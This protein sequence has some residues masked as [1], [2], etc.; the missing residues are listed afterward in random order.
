MSPRIRFRYV[1]VDLIDIRSSDIY[2][3][4]ICAWKWQYEQSRGNLQRHTKLDLDPRKRLNAF[5]HG[6][7]NNS[8]SPGT[9]RALVQR[10][11]RFT[12]PSPA[13]DVAVRLP[14]DPKRA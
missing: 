4:E 12:V 3:W 10:R 5:C 11:G 7:P 9:A 2:R 13:D 6:K 14:S 1:R 8:I